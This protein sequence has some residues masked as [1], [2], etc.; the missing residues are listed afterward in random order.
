MKLYVLCI[1]SC[2]S[3][4]LVARLSMSLPTLLL[5]SDV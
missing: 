3:V 4:M 2:L 5:E 1:D